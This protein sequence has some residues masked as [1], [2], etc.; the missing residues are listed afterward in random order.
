MHFGYVSCFFVRYLDISNNSF[1]YRFTET[2]MPLTQLSR[3]VS[4]DG[5]LG[6]LSSI[7]LGD[8]ESSHED[9]ANRKMAL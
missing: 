6:L 1:G 7:D 5:F 9:M 4:L 2:L 3:G 8:F